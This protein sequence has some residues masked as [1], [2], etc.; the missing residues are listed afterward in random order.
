MNPV[1]EQ[2]AEHTDM[3]MV[4]GYLDRID[5]AL[6]QGWAFIPPK[7][8]KHLIIEIFDGDRVVAR[9]KANQYREDLKAA[10]VGNGDH[11]FELRLPNDLFDGAP[12][13]LYARDAETGTVLSNC[14]MIISQKKHNAPQY[15]ETRQRITDVQGAKE[16]FN[17][18]KEK[19]GQ[20]MWSAAEQDFKESLRLNPKDAETYWMLARTVDKMDR[21]WEAT[22]F[23][24]K[25][26]D[27]DPRHAT[28]HYT[29]ATFL[30]K[31][32]RLEEA[33][34]SY[35]RSLA[36]KPE[37]FE[38]HFRLG[39]VLE[40]LGKADEAQRAYTYAVEYDTTGLGKN[41]GP[42]AYYESRQ[43]WAEAAAAYT[44]T[45]QKDNNNAELFYRLGTAYS[46]CYQWQEASQA[47]S[48]AISLDATE[49]IWHYQ[50]GFALERAGKWNDAAVAYKAALARHENHNSDWYYRLGYVLN[51]AGRNAEACEAYRWTRI[52][53]RPYGVDIP[54]PEADKGFHIVTQ[55][56]EYYDAVP[57]EDNTILYESFHGSSMSCNPYAIFKY[58]LSDTRFDGWTHVWVL[59]DKGRI[60]QKYKSR[61][62]IIFVS[63]NSDLYR[64]YLASSRYLINNNTFP[65]Y[66]MRK[67]GQIYLNTWHG[68]PLKTLGKD[69]KNQDFDYKNATRNFLHASH[70]VSPNSHT[71]EVMVGRH[72]IDGLYTGSLAET[73]YPRVDLTLNAT[74]SERNLLKK[75]LNIPEGKK[76]VLY[77]PTW[78]GQLGKASFDR[79][80]LF[81]DMRALAETEAVVLFR[82]HHMVEQ[83][84]S[85]A[86]K[87][88][89]VVPEDVDT[90][91][92]LSVVD[93]LITDYSS[94]Y[95]D[96]LATGK[97]VIHYVYD[98]ESYREERGLYFSL[99]RMPG[100]ICH[101][102]VE[103]KLAL[104]ALL[105]SESW[106]PGSKYIQAQ[107]EFCPYDDGGATK[108]VIDLIFNGDRTHTIKLSLGRK[109][110]LFFAGQF[111]ANGITSS[112][113]NLIQSIDRDRY[114]PVTVIDNAKVASDS[115]QL[116]RFSK[117]L[118]RSSVICR[119]GRMNITPEQRWILDRYVN[120]SSLPSE[121]MWG[122]YKEAYR[123]E[124]FRMFGPSKVDNAINYDGY[125]LFWSSVFAFGPDKMLTKNTVYLH[126]DMYGEW[127]VKYPFMEKVL[128][129]Y[130]HYDKL[131]SVTKSV[132]DDNR[133]NIS[134]AFGVQEHKFIY[135]DNPIDASAIVALSEDEIPY[136][137]NSVK[138]KNGCFDFVAIGRL[139][140]EK[141][142][143]K[144][145]NAFKR[146]HLVYPNTRLFV[147]GKGPLAHQ[148]EEQ[149]VDLGLVNA[150][151]LL[152]HQSNP[153]P[154]LKISDCLVLSSNHEGQGLV[155]L[156]ALTL[157]KIT[158]STDIAG[159]R[160]VLEGGYGL[161]VENSVNGLADG[162]I[163]VIE[164]N[165]AFR[166]FD[167]SQYQ[168]NAMEM[169]Y[170]KVCG[171]A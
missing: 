131:A 8:E 24:E 91:E 74:P 42:G 95:F 84:L 104:R 125:S 62:N 27:L 45:A 72:D 67:P 80:K 75:R 70:L 6:A 79:E 164:G 158:I 12:H 112:Y 88:V 30:E 51:N 1:I 9:G 161:L 64:R 148:L 92:L 49:S 63:R 23:F 21:T 107:K 36:L 37:E 52:L 17:A 73:G 3:P 160:S 34:Q 57:I 123:R 145:I 32:N 53:G 60:P 146:V 141:D 149:I 33:V 124:F 127:M 140:P 20:K 31:M 77:A 16:F 4:M 156:E 93:I 138:M 7:P 22:K 121:E 98:F 46:R 119:V 135:C 113:I 50:L 167:A 136:E 25:A 102:I 120:F 162:M 68:T 128:H 109:T 129:L 94:I 165:V 89:N 170:G 99:E 139:S 166:P 56:N 101:D 130:K 54:S 90:N 171:E 118:E 78:R 65:E 86:G 168:R 11:S 55:Y 142:H 83:F 69:I 15:G 59:S 122:L 154:F 48:K 19:F 155:L 39:H 103:V 132:N 81:R 133:C 108:R 10:G 47:Y 111:V 153:F 61:P 105:T 58:L 85:T 147:I 71:T 150:V 82:G 97:P 5:G 144:L 157:G 106:V 38:R 100:E 41:F 40:K 87:G 35:R 117:V 110:L 116:E 44:V 96:F 76:V 14:P 152:G 26:I 143:A 29:Y 43:L 159:P 28:W 18:G 115:G 126:N 134:G 66:Y 2:A 137:F 169:F 163:S 13:A 151:H 114:L